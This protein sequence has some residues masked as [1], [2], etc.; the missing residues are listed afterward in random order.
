MIELTVKYFLRCFEIF[1]YTI[2][3]FIRMFVLM[4]NLNKYNFAG[5]FFIGKNYSESAF[6]TFSCESSASELLNFVNRISDT[7]AHGDSE[8]TRCVGGLSQFNN[9]H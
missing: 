1:S 3:I 6:I 2:T 4:I 9:I 5:I 7:C 8:C